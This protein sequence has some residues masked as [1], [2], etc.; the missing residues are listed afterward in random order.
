MD[1]PGD[2]G[3]N[4]KWKGMMDN[5]NTQHRILIIDDDGDYRKLVRSW[6]GGQIP[7]GEVVEYDPVSD[8]IPG[9][10][11]NWSSFD[12]LLLDY[13]LNL[14]DVTGL[15]ILQANRENKLFPTTVML[16][17]A[18][19]ED[20]A[21]RAFKYGV[22]D[23]LR[24]ERIDRV[25]LID[26]VKNALAHE[27]TK[28]QHLDTMEEAIQIAQVESR[29]VI[30]TFKSKYAKLRELEVKRVKAERERIEQDLQKKQEVLQQIEQERRKAEEL[31]NYLLKEMDK[32]KTHATEADDINEQLEVTQE[33]L[34]IANNSINRIEQ[35]YKQAEA[36]V[37]RTQWKQEQRV[38]L[39]QQLENDMSIFRDDMEHHEKQMS[40]FNNKMKDRIDV[41]KDIARSKK[42]TAMKHDKN[43]ID[44]ISSGLGKEEQ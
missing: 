9:A 15:D 4:R 7:D 35:D 3:R 42:E 17:A 16:T 14:G 1:I 10:D 6:L 33:K 39:Q 19:S 24:K 21:V 32:M 34:V 2:F 12:V 18:G 8:G 26:A 5:N 23:Y 36:A 40:E 20:V 44:D 29:K 13:D 30:A 25:Q 22:L 41:L 31:K 11:F 28:R 43:L 27:V 37:A 38:E